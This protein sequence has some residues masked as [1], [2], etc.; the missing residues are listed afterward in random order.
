MENKGKQFKGNGIKKYIK[1]D[2][3]DDLGEEREDVVEYIISFEPGELYDEYG[4]E[5]ITDDKGEADD[6][7]D[8][9]KEEHKLDQVSQYIEKT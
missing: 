3:E 4:G 1:E 7:F 5:F 9:L 6:L 8:D 2:W